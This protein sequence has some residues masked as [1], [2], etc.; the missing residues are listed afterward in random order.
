MTLTSENIAAIETAPTPNVLPIKRRGRPTGVKNGEGV[1]HKKKLVK[2]P[3]V[4]INTDAIVANSEVKNL[5]AQV[6][7]LNEE[8][9]IA[10]SAFEGAKLHIDKVEKQHKAALI[11]VGY[12]EGKVFNE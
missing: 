12:L 6:N 3:R 2:K 8:L 7:R 10:K 1:T 9:R 4:R 5:T 11:V